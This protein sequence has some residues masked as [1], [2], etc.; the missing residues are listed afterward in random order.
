MTA[1]PVVCFGFET[2]AL[3]DAMRLLQRGA[4]LGKVV[5]RIGSTVRVP[6]APV[7]STLSLGNH[8]RRSTRMEGAGSFAH[9]CI[10]GAGLAKFELNDP[11]R[12][13]T[14]SDP[15]GEDVRQAV[16][17]LRSLGSV[18]ALVL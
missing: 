14:M 12:F 6:A 2:R 15:L 5:V 1:V 18:Y 13:N 16:E 10:S 3:Q 8:A 17:L 7:D 9:L 4:N 11:S